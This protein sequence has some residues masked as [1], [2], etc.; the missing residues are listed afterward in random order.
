VAHGQAQVWA[1]LCAAGAVAT[2]AAARQAAL[3]DWH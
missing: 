1:G 3:N 2:G